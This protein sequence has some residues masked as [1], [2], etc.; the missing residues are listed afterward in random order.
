MSNILTLESPELEAKF[1]EV[2]EECKKGAL[3]ILASIFTVATFVVIGIC[4]AAKW[5]IG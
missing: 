1:V 5:L 2:W 3:I 4:A